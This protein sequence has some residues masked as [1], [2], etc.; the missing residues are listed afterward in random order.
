VATV[1]G[2]PADLSDDDLLRL[3]LAV[4]LEQAESEGSVDARAGDPTS[5]QEET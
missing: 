3:L 4:N 1:Y 2:W 5:A